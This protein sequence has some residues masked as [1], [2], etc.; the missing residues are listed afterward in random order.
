[1]KNK[2]FLII[3]SLIVLLPMVAGILLWSRLPQELPTHWGVGDDPNGWSG[4]A[5]AVFGLPLIILGCHWL[6]IWAMGRDK[7]NQGHNRKLMDLILWIFPI[8]SVVS[9]MVVYG[10]ALELELNVS[11]WMM[12]LLGLLFVA[13][14][15]YLP[16]CKQNSTLGIKLKWTLYSEENWN[17]THRFG[18]KVWVLGGLLFMLTGFLPEK[19]L[20]WAL[21]GLVLLLAVAPTVYSWRLYKRQVKEG[22]WNQSSA[23]KEFTVNYARWGK[24]SAAAVVLI[25]ALVAVLMFTG[26]VETTLDGDTLRVEASYWQDL[27][28]PCGQIDSVEYREEGVDGTREWGY[29]SARLLLGTFQNEEFGFYT[30]YTYTGSGPCL[31]VYTGGDVVVLGCESE[32]QTLAL[33]EALLEHL[34]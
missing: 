21:P 19:A 1:M 6:C 17:K 4:K 15:N 24:I 27:E 10:A 30:R 23:S 34:N 11:T 33:Y 14:G 13:M 26:S 9:G 28:L 25:L 20:F 3:T 2:K 7:Q 8:V 12:V 18:G 31:V 32:G 22:T 5:F 29:G 16:K